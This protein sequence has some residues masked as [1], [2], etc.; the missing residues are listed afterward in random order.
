MS[1]LT[2][3]DSVALGIFAIAVVRGVFIGLI[4]EGFSIAALGG[5]LVSMRYAIEPVA[6]VIRQV[7]GGVGETASH[8]IAGAAIGIAV[9]AVIGVVGKKLRRGAQA[10]GLGWADRI[11]GGVIGAV[12][13]TLVAAVIVVAVTWVAGADS[14]IIT[15]SRSVE[16]LE[17]LQT[18]LAD[19]REELPA[20]AAPPGWFSKP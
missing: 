10:V 9:V 13:G 4:R 14:P 17:E 15:E 7:A 12:E 16:F 2:A 18:Y 5:G 3:L 19:H 11:A 1:D 8:W 6:S 20:V